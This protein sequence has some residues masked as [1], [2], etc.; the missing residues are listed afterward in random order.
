MDQLKRKII[1]L[2]IISIFLLNAVFAEE[3]NLT[4]ENKENKINTF[5][6]KQVSSDALKIIGIKETI[7]M[8]ELF[9]TSFLLLIV[10]G[11]LFGSV[12]FSKAMGTG[13]NLIISA[14]ITLIGSQSEVPLKIA[15]ELLTIE[16]AVEYLISKKWIIIIILVV[17]IALNI[18]AHLLL[19]GFVKAKEQEKQEKLA[20]RKR[21]REMLE[22]IRDYETDAELKRYGAE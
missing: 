6:Q 16:N 9:I 13:T 17:I 19:K 5:M 12:E 10:F 15:R 2:G 3:Y 20:E 22:K 18:L 11:I 21:K 14:I 4:I 8:K 1:F 7:S